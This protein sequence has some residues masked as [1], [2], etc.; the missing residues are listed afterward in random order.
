MSENPTTNTEGRYEPS[1]AE[2]NRQRMQ[3]GAM[4][5]RDLDRQQD[6]VGSGAGTPDGEGG[7]DG[8][9]RLNEDEA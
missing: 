5:A 1:Q 2:A 9:E 6:S 3:G 8:V 4:G 7:A